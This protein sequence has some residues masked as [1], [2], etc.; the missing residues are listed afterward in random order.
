MKKIIT[1]SSIC[2]LIGLLVLAGCQVNN[3]TSVESNPTPEPPAPWAPVAS[4][5]EIKYDADTPDKIII[6]GRR[7]FQS[8]C[9]SCHDSPTTQRI[10]GFANDDE[11][12]ELVIGMAGETGLPVEHSEKVI[13]YLLAVF[14]DNVP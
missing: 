1:I 6:E 7:T 2:L 12:L 14:H 4:L 10:K 3:N 5:E 8:A 11:L 9:S 13:R